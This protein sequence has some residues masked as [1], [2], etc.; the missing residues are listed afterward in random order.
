MNLQRFIKLLEGQKIKALT[1][2]KDLFRKAKRQI[3]LFAK[4]AGRYLKG[5]F[6]NEN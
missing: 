2:A 1:T 3:I 4:M 6:K 5:S